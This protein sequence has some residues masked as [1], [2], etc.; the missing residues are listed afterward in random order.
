MKT[1]KYIFSIILHLFVFNLLTAAVQTNIVVKNFYQEQNLTIIESLKNGESYSIEITS[2]GCFHGKRQ[3]IVVSKE[4]DVL[5]AKFQDKK[6]VLSKIKIEAFKTFE[7][8]LRSIS[9]GGC[10]TVDTYIIRY[11]NENFQTSDGTCSWN[12]GRKLLDVLI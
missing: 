6:V 8:E 10:T 2:I 11:G 9:I 5:I 12:G 7:K 4:A 3:T 1:T